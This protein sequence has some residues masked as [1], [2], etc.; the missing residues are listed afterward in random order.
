MQVRL[1]FDPRAETVIGSRIQLQQVLLNLMRNAHEA[2]AQSERR[3]LDVATARL[4]DE[5]IEIAVADRGPGLPDEIA[6]HLF[7]PF[8]T[9]KRN[10]MGLATFDLPLDRRGPWRKTAVSAQWRRRGDLSGYVARHA[11][12]MS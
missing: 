4:D 7:E 12:T 1:R 3:E 8:R 2:M 10:G 9:T 11:G 5:S 6:E